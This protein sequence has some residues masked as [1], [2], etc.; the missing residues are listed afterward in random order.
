VA[1]AAAASLIPLI[2]AVGHE[3]DVTLIDFAADK[4]APTPT[5]A[6]EMAVPVRAEL[7]AQIDGLARR[8]VAGWL[9]GLDARRRE[10]RA[11]ARALPTPETLLAS[12]RQ[13]LDAASDRL[14][15]AL[16]ANAQIH[17]TRF[18]RIA[19]RLTP[20]P[21]RAH[22][23]RCDE[24]V[25]ALGERAR[26]ALGVLSVRRRDRLEVAGNRLATGL[27][28][29]RTAQTTRIARQRE[30]V[31]ALI[32]RARRAAAAGLDRR[33][34]A[35]ERAAQLL[36]ALSYQGVLRRGFALVRDQRAQPLRSAL[37]VGVGTK[38]DIEFADGRVGATADR[39]SATPVPAPKL[40]RRRGG[41]GEGQGSLF[42]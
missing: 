29:Y 41:G 30:G 23:R 36:A 27:R 31:A 3:T 25:G 14:P 22:T 35:V 20:A 7:I 26:R 39:T 18:S 42:G 37:A 13:L 17:H 38:L 16:R 1:R 6:A 21:L 11:A 4:R 8:N 24:K 12:P 34:A 33:D 32:E 15:R 19:A 10:L 5:A 9:R 28:A 2:S 40:R